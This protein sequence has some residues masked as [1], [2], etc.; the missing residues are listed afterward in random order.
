MSEKEDNNDRGMN[1]YQIKFMKQVSR[2]ILKTPLFELGHEDYKY[3]D[4]CFNKL[5]VSEIQCSILAIIGFGCAAIVYDLSFDEDPNSDK[6]LLSNC[7][8]IVCS[9]STLLLLASII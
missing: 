3:T 7:L 8:Y 4:E 6:T 1:K 2:V 5:K 9:I